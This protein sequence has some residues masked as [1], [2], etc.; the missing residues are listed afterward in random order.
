[1]QALKVT[2]PS[3]NVTESLLG[4]MHHAGDAEVE[5]TRVPEPMVSCCL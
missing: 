3:N 1:M 5:K 4:A 2:H